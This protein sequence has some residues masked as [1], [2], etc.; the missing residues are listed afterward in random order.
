M[1]SLLQQFASAG[2]AEREAEILALGPWF[3]NLHLPDGA[4][5][6]PHS[7]L[8]DFPRWK[9]EEVAPHVPADLTGWTALDIGCN[10]GFYAFELAK[11]GARVT[12][13]DVEPLFLRQAE[14]AAR[15]F[16]LA[17]RVDFRRMAV[18]DLHQ[19]EGRYDL[20]LFMGVLY[21]LRY[22]ML[23]LDLVTEKVGRMMVFQTLTAPGQGV[24]PDT[25]RDRDVLDRD[26]LSDPS[27][28][29]LSFLEH[30]FAGDETNW[31]APNH[32]GVE[33]ML[34]SSGMRVTGRPGHEI[35]VCEPDAGATP[36]P[37]GR[38]RPELLA[39]TGRPW[40]AE[41]DRRDGVGGA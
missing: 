21:H 35:Y 27:W 40:A 19:L 33:A 34:R 37:R 12:G 32:A 1:T 26:D 16:D 23:G 22:P 15:E 11:R 7:A 4:Q 5:T 39:A 30:P 29:R 13:I 25:A 6:A 20:V 10:A 24:H 41:A 31:W 9:W 36:W 3:H 38:G 14:W 28:P 17:D 2:T 18:Y 8:G